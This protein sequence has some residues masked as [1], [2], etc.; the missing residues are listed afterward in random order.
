MLP[1][2]E[3]SEQSVSVPMQMLVY[4]REPTPLKN[5][6]TFL[7][8]PTPRKSLLRISIDAV[9]YTTLVLA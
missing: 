7:I 6:H 5:S 1:L 9:C 4:H 8:L 3:N 2:E